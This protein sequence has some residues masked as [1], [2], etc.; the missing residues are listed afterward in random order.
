MAAATAT[1]IWETAEAVADGRPRRRGGG[2]EVA[3]HGWR[4]EQRAADR[5]TVDRRIGRRNCRRESGGGGVGADLCAAWDVDGTQRHPCEDGVV[6]A[7]TIK[8]D[9]QSRG[10]R[11]DVRVTSGRGEVDGEGDH[12]GLIGG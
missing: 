7:H 6:A 2:C 9:R 11:E 12:G 1:A 3:P 10:K 5:G 4:G 8:R